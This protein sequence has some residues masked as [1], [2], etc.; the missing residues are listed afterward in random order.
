VVNQ[1]GLTLIEV[2]VL[3]AILAFVLVSFI[4][5]MTSQQRQSSQLSDKIAA[6][7]LERSLHGIFADANVCTF[8][9]STVPMTPFDPMNLPAATIPDFPSIPSRAAAGAAPLV[10]ANGTTL[11]SPLSQRLVATA[12]R[13]RNLACA[14]PPCTPTSNEF[15]AQLAVEFD[16]TKTA[17]PVAPVLLPIRLTTAGGA[18][19]QTPNGCVL[20]AAAGGGGGGGGTIDRVLIESPQSCGGSPAHP[21][22]NFVPP[23]VYATCPA[24]YQ[25]TGCGY[26]TIWN[27]VD[28]GSGDNFHSNSPDD[29]YFD[30]SN[31]C[32]MDAGGNPGCGVCF[33]AQAVC[34]RIQ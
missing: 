10:E 7:D 6:I 23:Y 11:V 33:V 31:S 21:A 26:R 22:C 34:L 28:S 8:L 15:D 19:A 30:G 17:G 14:F 18:G 4:A 32:K 13:I 3:S 29:I 27:P 2:L 24:G 1:R 12:V 16:N 25:L 9:L 20:N 5:T